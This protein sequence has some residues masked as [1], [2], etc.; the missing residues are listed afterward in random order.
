MRQSR[1]TESM[2][3]RNFILLFIWVPFYMPDSGSFSKVFIA[4]FFFE[5]RIQ[6]S[7]FSFSE[8]LVPLRSTGLELCSPVCEVKH[9]IFWFFG[10][11]LHYESPGYALSESKRKR[12]NFSSMI[13]PLVVYQCSIGCPNA[14]AHIGNPKGTQS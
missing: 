11:T 10:A 12:A 3:F 14:H 13:W 6:F 2:D 7:C 1:N 5:Y 9:L 8:W 4:S